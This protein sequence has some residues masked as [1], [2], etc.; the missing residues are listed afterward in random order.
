MK[1]NILAI[2]IILALGFSH[3]QIQAQGVLKKVGSKVGKAIKESISESDSNTETTK[4][5]SNIDLNKVKV[6]TNLPER[7]NKSTSK[8]EFKASAYLY[9]SPKGNNRNDG[10][11]EAPFK[12]IQKAV[13]EAPE[14][15]LIRVAEG[16]Y[17]GKLN[18]GYISIKKYVGLEGGYSPDFSERDP[19]KYRTSIQPRPEQAGTNSNYGLFDIYVSG[20]PNGRI[21]IDGFMLDKGQMNRYVSHAA[22]DPRFIVPE[23]LETGHLNPPGMVISQPSMRGQSSVSNQLIHGDVEGNVIIRNCILLNGSHYGIQMG[24]KGGKWEVYN[25][26]F[27]TNRMAACE[28]RGMNNKPGASIVEF[29]HNTVLFSWRRDWV[30]ADKDMG[31]GYRFM[32]R[33]DSD[34]HHNIFGC[35]DFSALDRTRID[36]D[37]NIEASRKTSSYENLFFNNIEADIALPS[38]G[39]KFMRIFAEDFEDVDQLAIADDNRELNDDEINTFS[40]LIDAAYLKAFLNIESSTSTSYNPNSSENTFRSAMGMNQR[41]TETNFVSMYGNAYPF[42]KAA[43][44]F[45]AIEGYGAQKIE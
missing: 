39:G 27:I 42:E 17:L 43:D 29:H 35:N 6:E 14:G 7:G 38:G 2:L 28:I 36:S 15:A 33:V 25:N 22:T 1:K 18:A 12:D 30:P 45:G 19:I 10:S 20:N 5:E 11:K 23:G 21:L 41:G 37:K 31:Y 9:V 16:N 44:L 32:T 13:D 24:H 40:K 26:L 8:S 4:E 34:V 3:N